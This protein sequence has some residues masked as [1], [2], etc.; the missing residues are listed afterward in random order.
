[1]NIENYFML[2]S[3]DRMLILEFKKSLDN[4]IYEILKPITHSALQECE[5]SVEKMHP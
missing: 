4:I 2:L 1:V 3:V 5:W